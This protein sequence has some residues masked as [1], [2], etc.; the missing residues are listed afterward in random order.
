ME[1]SDSQTDPERN[2]TKLPEYQCHKV[3]QAA[4]IA[5]VQ[6]EHDGAMLVLE[7]PDDMAIS[8]RVSL[9]WHN[10]HRPV[11]GDYLVRYDDGYESKSPVDPFE[12]GYHPIKRDNQM[13][14]G[15]ALE[16]LT[17]KKRVARAGWNG[18]DMFIFLVPGSTFE[19]NRPPLLGIY[20]EGTV[21]DY[22]PHIDMRT[23]QGY[24]VPWLAS[25]SDLLARDWVLVG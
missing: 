25:Q 9:N 20:A 12:D 10:R 1:T 23:A 21:I 16:M 4:K 5:Q 8:H 14:F 6:V 7:I 24:I 3:V 11:P 18:K 2:F 19:V 15:Q 17:A 22:L 13:D